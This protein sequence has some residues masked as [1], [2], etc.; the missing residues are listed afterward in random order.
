MPSFPTGFRP[1]DVEVNSSVVRAARERGIRVYLVGGFLRD[2][3]WGRLSAGRPAKDFDYAVASGSAVS[4][5]RFLAGR[6][7]GHFVL[8]DQDF[9]TARIVLESGQI[10]DFAGCLGGSIE[11]DVRRRDFTINGLVWDP[12]SPDEILDLCGG[13]A[14]VQGKVVRAIADSNFDDDPLRLLRAFRFSATLEA[15]IERSTLEM[16]ARKSSRLAEVAGERVSYEL[17]TI[18]EASSTAAIVK[19][20][21]EAGI[22][23]AIFP[24]LTATKKVTPNA[25]HH[26]GLWDHSLELVAQSERRLPGLP[27]WVH[28]DLARELSSGISRLSASKVA[29]L[30]HDIG[31][32]ETWAITPEGRH[33]FYGHDRLGAELS[34]KIGERLKWSRPLERFIVKLVHF[35]LRPGQLFH[36]GLPTER[37]VHRFYRSIGEDLPPLLLLA[38]ADLG[39]T[40]GEGL[41]EATRQALD[42]NL[43]GLLERYPAFIAGQEKMA[44]LLDG[45]EIMQLLGIKPGPALGDLIEALAEAQGLGEVSNRAQ[46]EQFVRERYRQKYMH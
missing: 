43:L 26:L 25:Y 13:L 30:L 36:Q 45:H 32:P 10:L 41:P 46:A 39:A 5:A 28:A 3:L 21:G 34:E 31:K 29:C 23:E 12:E 42:H 24:E 22:L 14:D 15:T 38:F 37:A 18:M 2:A 6:L 27:D 44:R 8:L 1:L 35:H 40:C 16:I 4:F 11:A 7:S 20:M 33:T 17:F 19:A 9:D